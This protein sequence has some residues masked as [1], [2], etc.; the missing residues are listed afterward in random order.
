VDSAPLLS[1]YVSCSFVFV[2]HVRCSLAVA[3]NCFNRTIKFL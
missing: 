3:P 2:R 1:V